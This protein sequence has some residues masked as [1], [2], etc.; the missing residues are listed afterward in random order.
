[1]AMSRAEAME[2]YGLSPEEC[3]DVPEP[4]VCPECK[5]QTLFPNGKEMYG[6]DRDGRRGVPL[7]Y[8]ICSE[9]GY[10]GESF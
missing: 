8:H 1:M 3:Y 4:E 10:E 9:C 6:T 5:E 7:Y 2:H